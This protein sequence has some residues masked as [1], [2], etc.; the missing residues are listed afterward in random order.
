ML[1]SSLCKGLGL[2]VTVKFTFR[3]LTPTW[4]VTDACGENT[5]GFIHISQFSI[6]ETARPVNHTSG[7]CILR[8]RVVPDINCY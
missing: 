4:W 2:N 7:Y 8:G 5:T 1:Y 3:C 6:V